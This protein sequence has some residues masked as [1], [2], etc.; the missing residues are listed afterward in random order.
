MLI[1]IDV[2]RALRPNPTGTERYSLEIVRHLVQQ[3]DAA[4]H[5]WCFYTDT[6]SNPQSLK[7]NQEQLLQLWPKNA[8]MRSIPFQKM[9]THRSLAREVMTNPPD[10]LFV[11]AHVIPFSWADFLRIGKRLPPSVVTIHDLGY[12]H[13]PD[14]HTWQQQSYLNWSTRWSTSIADKVIAVSEATATDIQTFYGT[15]AQKIAV[16]Y[17]AATNPQPQPSAQQIA[18]TRRR[19]SLDR[20]Y[21]FYVGTI[22]P[23]KNLRRLMEAYAQLCRRKKANFELVLGGGEGWMSQLLYE[24]ADSIS[25]QIHLLGYVNDDDL[26]AL[27]AGAQFFCLPSLFEGFGLPVLEAQYYG[28]PV[29]TAN[30]SSLP[31]V[32]GDAAILVDPMDVDAIAQ[33]M[34]QLSQD[35]DLRQRLIAAGHENV[36]R[37][38]WE[39]AAQ[40]TLAVLEK[41]ARSAK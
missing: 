10:V 4:H 3:P 37:F 26:P 13:F 39:K 30:N 6:S 19:Y 24:L 31:E 15:S 35:E 1:G 28:T 27:M 8:E 16:I 5:E 12:L 21:A 9:W 38:S 23:R 25:D 11:P 33:T 2:S 22:Q 41:A 34:L 20:P 17:E 29:M 32:A 7:Q 40:E 14:A 36:K 18:E